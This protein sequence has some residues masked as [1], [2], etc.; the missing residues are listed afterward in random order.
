MPTAS[1][2]LPSGMPADAAPNRLKEF[3]LRLGLS[4]SDVAAAIGTDKMQISRLERGERRLTPTLREKLA[5]ALR[6]EPDDLLPP[7]GGRHIEPKAMASEPI[8]PISLPG[9]FEFRMGARDLPIRGLAMGG[10]GHLHL[11]SE[12]VDWTWRPPELLGVT[13]AF[14]VFV[15]GDSMEDAV[16]EGTILLVHP[17]QPAR[18]RDLCVLELASG[19]VVI[20]RLL[21]RTQGE[22]HLRQYN[23]SKDF[24]LPTSQ[25]KRCFRVVG[26]QL[27]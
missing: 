24:S 3:R 10:D 27:P 16:L 12:T 11:S 14:A 26:L 23:P 7:L 22:Y 19:E 21:R 4:Q 25:V 1:R 15:T 6:C 9:A 2:D 20:K 8:A 5:V 18:P 13:D 17:H